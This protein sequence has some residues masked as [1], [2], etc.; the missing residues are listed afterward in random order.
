MKNYNIE[1]MNVEELKTIREL[2]MRDLVF[3]NLT[4]NEW[5]ILSLFLEDINKMIEIKYKK[6]S[7]ESFTKFIDDI[8]QNLDGD[9]D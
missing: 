8:L 2:F 5:K 3:E 4:E 9:D 7:K 6:Q 1:S